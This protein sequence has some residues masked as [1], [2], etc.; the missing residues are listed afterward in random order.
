MSNQNLP[1]YNSPDTA[2][3]I[4]QDRVDFVADHQLP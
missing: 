1:N 4:T 3:T 2:P